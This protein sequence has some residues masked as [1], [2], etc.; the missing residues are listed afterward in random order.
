M[1]WS[2]HRT[3]FNQRPRKLLP[4]GKA[5]PLQRQKERHLQFRHTSVSE[6]FQDTQRQWWC[7]SARPSLSFQSDEEP[8]QSQRK[9]E[10]RRRICIP[11]LLEKTTIELLGMKFSLQIWLYLCV[12]QVC[13]D[14]AKIAHAFDLLTIC[15]RAKDSPR[16]STLDWGLTWEEIK[17]KDWIW[18]C[19]QLS[20]TSPWVWRSLRFRPCFYSRR[21]RERP[22]STRPTQR[23]SAAPKAVRYTATLNECQSRV[24]WTKVMQSWRKIVFFFLNKSISDLNVVKRSVAC[25]KLSVLS[26]PRHSPKA[27]SGRGRQWGLS[28][29]WSNAATVRDQNFLFCTSFSSPSS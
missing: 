11:W 6:S 28:D 17:E 8:L 24:N 19:L 4:F 13:R 25:E 20:E 22:P 23:A 3:H 12:M 18:T 27:G 26:L 16:E 14:I 7:I 2:N 29:M 10:S 9:R 21:P 5:R 15:P 1:S